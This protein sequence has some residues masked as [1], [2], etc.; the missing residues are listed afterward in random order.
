MGK[1]IIDQYSLLHFAS[2]I[3]AY[4]W[5]I[6]LKWWTILHLSFEFLENTQIGMNF[7]NIYFKDIWPGG[8]P[9]ADNLMNSMSDNFFGI[10]GWLIAYYVDYK[11]DEMGLYSPH[12]SY[13][14]T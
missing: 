7:I 14:N 10:I 4:F 11:G 6:S 3:I 8:K 5:G 12:I 2:G 13:N 9:Y 1:N